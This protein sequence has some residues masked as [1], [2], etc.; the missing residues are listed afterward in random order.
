MWDR[1]LLAGLG[2]QQTR[3]AV[4]VAAAAAAA[5]EATAVM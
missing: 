4:V 3:Q 5:V 1:R 2:R